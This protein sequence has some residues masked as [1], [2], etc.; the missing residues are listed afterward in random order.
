MAAVAAAPPVDHLAPGELIAGSEQAFGITLPRDVHVENRFPGLVY[1][2]GQVPFQSLV[3]YFSAR[4]EQGG[5]QLYP[6]RATFEQVRPKGA[7]TPELRIEVVTSGTG[8]VLAE[9]EDVTPPPPRPP[10]PPP[11]PKDEAAR[12]KHLGLTPEGRVLDKK[13]LE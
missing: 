1:V 3:D 7:M 10:G 9:L 5:L 6:T 8:S 2:R 4:V 13:R 11:D 12:W